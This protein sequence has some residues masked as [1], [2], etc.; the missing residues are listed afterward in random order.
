MV[1]AGTVVVVAGTVLVEVSE[2]ASDVFNLDVVVFVVDCFVVSVM[3]GTSSP[4]KTT[5]ICCDVVV[6]TYES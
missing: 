1:V 4:P 5:D 2:T 6:M 3:A